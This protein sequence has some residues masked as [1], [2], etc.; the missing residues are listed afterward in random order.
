MRSL[1]PETVIFDVRVQRGKNSQAHTTP[2]ALRS[3][4]LIHMKKMLHN[5]MI[6]TVRR[7]FYQQ[8]LLA[9]LLLSVASWYFCY[10]NGTS[11]LY[12]DA[13][14]HLNLSRLVI[15]NME[16]GFS[17]LGGVWLPLNHILPL[18]FIW[19][20]WA[21]HSGF[22]GSIVSMISYIVSVITVYQIV[23][24]LTKHRLAS[25]IGAL[26]FAV[27]LNM[28]Y[29]QSTPM[30]EP[31]YVAIFC[32]SAY[33]FVK[34][35]LTN[36]V[37]Y[38]LLLGLLGFLQVLSRYDGWFVV[39]IEGL[40][41]IFHELVTRR[42]SISE[43]IGKLLLFSFPV[44]FGVGMWLAWNLLIFHDPFFFAF[45]PY[46]AH[47]QQ[48]ISEAHLDL[49]TKGNVKN[50]VLA[51]TYAVIGNLGY[52]AIGLSLAGVAFFFWQKKLIRLNAKYKSA[53]VV[54]LSAPILFNILALYLGFSALKI[55]ELAISNDPAQM[56]FNVR[57]GILALPMASVF[58]GVFASW[59][60]IISSFIALQIIILQAII[61][62]SGI[63]TITDGAIGASSF[64]NQ[65]I[66]VYL[67]Q[68]V[69]PGQKVLLAT[70]LYSPVAF[71]SNV[72]LKQ[73][74]HEGVSK[75]WNF[76]L[77]NPQK[78]TTWIV[79]ANGDVGDPIYTMMVKEEQNRFLQF[80]SLDFR[81]KYANIYRIKNSSAPHERL[82]SS[83]RK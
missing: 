11:T 80:Y 66:S 29:L 32:L 19:N 51:Y 45:G 42:N 43:T 46:S 28:L 10:S 62:S 58:I 23:N 76:A 5:P 22:A 61:M 31:L 57:Y 3:Y 33:V 21:W 78:Y 48:K 53:I 67:Q 15:D 16:P 77:K 52:Y 35:I 14:S 75:Q 8:A 65:D 72:P 4:F 1:K 27:N 34:H 39:G 79:M 59:R 82:T 55:P 37:H 60:K 63:V 49:I 36:R 18:S 70:S 6:V 12:N 68:T 73:I 81:G 30:T 9:V 17:Q 44:A 50:S 41:I 24:N 25:L 40:I 74:I 20:D 38:L 26:S 64:K 7:S 69:K 54:F 83:A 13:M 71:K 2:N 47:A 56:W